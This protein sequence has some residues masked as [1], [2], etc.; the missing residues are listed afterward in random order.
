[1]TAA[2]L[3]AAILAL[4]GLVLGSY[5]IQRKI[6]RANALEQVSMVADLKVEQIESAL[7]AQKAVATALTHGTIMARNVETWTESGR[8]A[9][10]ASAQMLLRLRVV[11]ED[12]H[13][14]SMVVLRPDGTPLMAT[15]EGERGPSAEDLQAAAEVRRTGKP[16]F[17]S[18]Y[19]NEQQAGKPASLDLVA[20]MIRVQPSGE[21]RTVALLLLRLDPNTFLYPF[22]QQWPLPSPTAETLIAERR[23]DRVWFLNE[24]RHRK[25]MALHFNV[26]ITA[27]EK[28][29]VQAALGRQGLLEG[30]DYR[31]VAV[32]GAG[33][34]VPGTPWL[35]V[36]KVDTAEVYR[37]LVLR[38]LAMSM[39]SLFFLLTVFLGVHSWMR[40][41]DA[42]L[43]RQRESQYRDLFESMAD[44]IM[45]LEPDG[46]FIEFNQVALDQLGYSREE[47]LAMGPEKINPP[48]TG[49]LVDEVHARL[50]REGTAT[51]ETRHLR[52]DG[53]SFPVE[54]HSRWI[55]IG[56]RQL[57]LSS[58]HDITARKAAEAEIQASQARIRA[59]FENAGVG[60]A[61]TDM[62]GRYLEVNP[63]LAGDLGYSREDMLE[64]STRDTLHPD[65]WEKSKALL[66]GLLHTDVHS[67]LIE[68]RF[69][70]KDGSILWA[71]VAITPIYDA[72]GEV[73][74]VIKMMIDITARKRVEE[75]LSLTSERLSIA[76]HGAGI[77]IWDWDVVQDRLVWD[78]ELYRVFGVS[79]EDFGAAHAAWQKL[80]HP[81]DIAR[82]EVEIAAALR[83]ER[84]YEPEFRICWPDGSIHQIKAVARVLRDEQ[85]KP[86]RMV[87]V[88][89]D[90]TARVVAERELKKNMARLQAILSNLYSGV[91]VVS[92]DGRVD[93]INDCM[94]EIFGLEAKPEE[95]VGK[96]SS[97]LLRLTPQMALHPEEYAARVAELIAQGQRC[98]DEEYRLRNGRVILRDF[99]PLVIDGQAAGRVWT[100]RDITAMRQAEEM[101]RRVDERLRAM[102]A[103]H[104]IGTRPEQ[105]II[106][107]AVEDLARLTGSRISYLHF[108][109]YDQ[110]T[111]S[112]V[113]WN[114]ATLKDCD[115]AIDDHYPINKAGLWAD[116]VRQ[117]KA[118]IHNDFQ[119][120][121]ERKGYPEGHN[122]IVNHM[123]VP[124]FDGEVVAAVAGVGNKEGAYEDEDV[125]QLTL[126]TGGLWNLIRRKRAEQ[127]V[128]ENEQF[129][130]TVAEA[131]PGIVGHWSRELRCTFANHGY[132]EWFGKTPEQMLG[133][134]LCEFMGEDVFRANEARIR[135]A[136]DGHVE[137]YKR[138]IV[139]PDGSTGT[140]YGCYAPDPYQ[141]EERGFFVVASN[142]TELEEAQGTL[143]KLNL[144]LEE[145]TR[146]AEE[147]NRA[148]SDF[149][150]NMS[151]EIRTPMNA[152]IGLSH[153][154]LKTDL[155]TRQQDYLTRIQAASRNLL[156]LINDILDLSKI[157]AD[158]MEIELTPLNLRQVID[159]VTSI[160]A[161]KAH[162]K[163]LEVLTQ[164]P[165]EIPPA[166][167][168]D[169]LRLS[170]VL[171]NLASNA[172]KFT[173][174]G[175]VSLAVEILER[176]RERVRLRFSVRDTGIGIAAEALPRLFQ[177]FSQADTSTT[178][179]FGGS[180][181]GLA[182]SKRLVELMGGSIAVQSEEGKG[183]TFSFELPLAIAAR[184]AE[185]CT[186]S[187]LAAELLGRKVL[188]VDDDADESKIVG[189][190]LDGL[191]LQAKTC[192]SGDQ[193]IAALIRAERQ[194]DPF[195][196]VLLDWRMPRMDGLETARRIRE[197]ARIVHPPALALLTAYGGEEI[198]H[199][200]S[201]M[202]IDT[203]LLK[204][205]SASLLLDTVVETLGRKLNAG[206][207]TP[208]QASG[209]E[210]SAHCILLAEDNETNRMV[211]TEM[212]EE[213][214]YRVVT[215]VNGSEAVEKVLAP[216]A[217]F[218]LIL[219]DVQMPT[220]DG[221]QA[222]EIIRKAGK[223][224][225]IVAMTAQA[226]K[227]EQQRCFAVGMN[228]HLTKPFE[229]EELLRRLKRWLSAAP[230]RAGAGR[231]GA[232]SE[233][234]D[235]AAMVERF[236]GDEH[237][238]DLLLGAL[239]RDLTQNR[240]SLHEALEG[241]NR[242]L[243][244]RV[245]HS[246]KGLTGFFQVNQL[247]RAAADLNEAL[248]GRRDWMPAARVL[249]EIAASTLTQLTAAQS[250]AVGRSAAPG[251][252]RGAQ[253]QV[254]ELHRLLQRKSL[255]ARATAEALAVALGSEPAAER[256]QEAVRSLDF[257]RA[258]GILAELAKA[259]DFSLTSV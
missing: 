40:Q 11:Q 172:V 229:P 124:I 139:K 19:L 227:S 222:T 138:T 181:L 47:L 45:V 217:D 150:A 214:G 135:S 251:D 167:L 193:A 85:G 249:E 157:E 243:A 51:F 75:E 259:H 162:E 72:R 92:A 239:Q 55:E 130:R 115:I 26:P 106:E 161:E 208:A 29:A 57:V 33:R 206:V 233:T 38:T 95:L 13:Y 174:R 49:N 226:M 28:L 74:S 176:E 5:A 21:S 58:V 147:A 244:G 46:H 81:E 15:A 163:G 54:I 186:P 77:G 27:G 149:L 255:S 232:Q 245:A 151:H 88:N 25:G 117:R 203:I 80:I 182:I 53:S 107:A 199:R 197:D 221:L 234:L 108:V 6:I 209:E 196:M 136:L 141:G 191:G 93:L 2:L 73:H 205:V 242:A 180:G 134:N 218:D 17:T 82:T 112:L 103:L 246:L 128:I 184:E 61:V 44:A 207:L 68:K 225:P 18:F 60:I 23:G 231:A 96:T 219:M 7:E 121:T 228:D 140:L 152:I 119:N 116:S 211:A 132:L 202:G 87:G 258:A 190:L 252:G 70:R 24:L 63:K 212:L 189:G 99:I 143:E 32:L 204:P 223:D 256:L 97:E 41:R 235:R 165:A 250:A 65:D 69:L 16:Q 123:S 179:R 194:H 102:I 144:D 36:A 241:R 201:E 248:S 137:P 183:S 156:S 127:K 76:T 39:V 230:A 67:A 122:H 98:Q 50:R 91:L 153:L 257:E 240:Q 62:E 187:L 166:L 3:A 52:K 154:V 66:S 37:P 89:F 105:E 10:A 125:R 220:M 142:V 164:L 215:V 120:L 4:L 178:R 71:L 177:S 111:L 175:Q 145:R 253:A 31:D 171:L 34:L 158:K 159:Q 173:E 20:P 86:L 210:A 133:M 101:R 22:L 185:R 83:G 94:C 170:Q 146:Q 90:I 247:R 195:E 59:V 169:S 12:N 42:A 100:H 129:L 78:D 118:V 110:E 160:L 213:A 254:Q 113:A 237:K 35:L 1:L 198:H 224:M 79:R 126:F 30:V 84:E 131:M 236:K 109:N 104:N 148:K 14:R 188:V 56:G 43:L 216:G 168:G 64:L 8:V 9:S 192:T 48:D 238:V 155:T 200:A 114:Q